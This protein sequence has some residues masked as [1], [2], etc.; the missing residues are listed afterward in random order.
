MRKKSL[1]LLSAIIIVVTFILGTTVGKSSVDYEWERVV[2][3][4]FGN[5]NNDYIW[6]MATYTD[7]NG[8]EWFYAGTM[9]VGPITIE[10]EAEV[11]RSFDGKNWEFVRSFPGFNGLRGATEY[12]G[13]LWFGTLKQTEEEDGCQI[14][15]TDGTSWKIASPAGFG[16]GA[17]STRGI[18]QYQGE[19]Y[20]DAGAVGGL[21]SEESGKIFK[22]DGTVI[23]GDLDSINPNSWVDV[24]P[25]EWGPLHP[26]N[27]ASE[28]IEFKGD[29]YVGTWSTAYAG[30]VQAVSG[31]E[32][33]RYTPSESPAWVQVSEPGFGR[34]KNIGILSSAV[35]K[36]K[37]YF[38]TQNAMFIGLYGTGRG[39]EVWRWDGEEWERVINKGNPQ[40]GEE[41]RRDNMYM[42]SMIEY[43]DQLI[44]G[45]FNMFRGGELW[46]SDSGDFGSFRLINDPGMYGSQLDLVWQPVEEIQIRKYTR[47]VPVCAP[48]PNP[49]K[50]YLSEQYGIR[51]LAKF[52]NKLYVGTAS[53]A[54]FVDWLAFSPP[55]HPLMPGAGLGCPDEPTM[56]FLGF[57]MHSPKVGCE[58]WRI[59]YLPQD[60]L[61]IIA[62][63]NP[64]DLSKNQTVTFS[65]LPLDAKIFIYTVSGE[66]VRVLALEPWPDTVEGPD[67]VEWDCRNENGELVARG[68]YIIRIVSLTE[69]KMGKIAIIK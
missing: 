3:D 12:A 26:I 33:W 38:G 17:Q 1:L 45:T 27:S 20:A 34:K 25:T 55:D 59:R 42:W 22:Y 65:H 30:G 48:P 35:F 49:P 66:L 60:T 11:Y 46:A 24:S 51:S 64:C 36:D 19:L 9:N 68:I 56:P 32:V 62:Y 5:L 4:G 52:K 50:A 13:L 8:T 54:Y 69:T 31:C 39:A 14:W 29:L 7:G 37:L 16:I 18:T 15:V 21:I 10:G 63:P 47:R 28:M 57:Y 61:P 41:R 6:T 2:K 23:E 67:T 44:V 58:I 40:G 53:W 43:E